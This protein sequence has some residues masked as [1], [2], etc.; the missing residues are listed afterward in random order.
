MRNFSTFTLDSF[1]FEISGTYSVRKDGSIVLETNKKVIKD[2]LKGY[3]A[4][5]HFVNKVEIHNPDLDSIEK[6]NGP[7]ELAIPFSLVVLKRKK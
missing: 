3:V 5:G 6:Y 2:S 1:K 7:F 4:H